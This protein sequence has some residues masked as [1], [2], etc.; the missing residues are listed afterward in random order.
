MPE[1]HVPLLVP[2][3]NPGT[4]TGAAGNNTWLIDGAFP[5]L[6]DAGIG[7]A[8]H[9]A[10]I[11]RA[12]RARALVRV[13][14]THSHPDHASGVPALRRSWPSLEACKLP[15]RGEA[16]WRALAD[17]DTVA[18]G[19]AHLTVVH[20]PGHAPDHICFWDADRRCLYGGDMVVA[21]ST[22][23]IPFGRGGSL[24]EYLASLERL[25]ALAPDRIYP[26]HGDVIERPLDVIGAYLEHRR[27]RERQI[28]EC[29]GDGVTGV[30]AI[31]AR[32]YPNLPDG[33]RQ[34]ARLTVEAHLQKLRDEGRL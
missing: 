21:G 13:L 18:A 34:P 16:G 15:L 19:D 8:P 11:T 23:M 29:L 24:T 1:T 3:G 25:A 28:L 33:L 7:T 5:T 17:G 4:L 20:T 26:G 12:L 31:A 9:V 14:V 10:A 2:A 22:V 27:F 6:V 30:D 32:L